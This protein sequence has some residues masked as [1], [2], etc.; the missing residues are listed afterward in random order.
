[1]R[2]SM[3]EFYFIILLGNINKVCTIG[4]IISGAALLFSL[5]IYIPDKKEGCL[6]ALKYVKISI[7]IFLLCLFGF[8]VIPTRTECYQIL[9]LGKTL[10][11]LQSNETAKQLPD[12]A[13][14]ALETLLDDYIDKK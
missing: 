3:E 11:Y 8:I 5:A 6:E 2:N 7:T 14:K 13:I 12:K 10:D 4:L 1:M 9:G